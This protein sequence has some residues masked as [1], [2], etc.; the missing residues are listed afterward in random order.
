MF[1]ENL[2]VFPATIPKTNDGIAEPWAI[3]RPY[4]DWREF[5]SQHIITALINK[6]INCAIT[7]G[8]THTLGYAIRHKFR[9]GIFP[10]TNNNLTGKDPYQTI[11]LLKNYSNTWPFLP[12]VMHSRIMS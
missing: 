9:N 8:C 1:I 4:L 10:T 5:M 7:V 11:R 6:I 2:L 12:R 3:R